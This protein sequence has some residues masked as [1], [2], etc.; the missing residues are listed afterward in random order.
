MAA[1]SSGDSSALAALY[2]RHSS[3]VYGLCVRILKERTEAEEVL[4]D[5]FLEIWNRA[6]RFDA[7]RGHPLTYLLSL[8]RSRALDRLRSRSR[9]DRVVLYTSDQDR[10]SSSGSRAIATSD[11]LRDTL[12]TELRAHLDLA[13]GGLHPAQ[14][15]AL[16][17]AYFDGM[18]HSEIAA[19]LGEPLGTVKTRI[20][21]GLIHL[22][23]SLRPHYEGGATP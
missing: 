15:R 1:I 10:S 17:L 14:R 2:D 3:T 12:V 18:S 4:G 9:R 21:Q 13:L 19:A 11:P 23:E 22:R 6:D 20:R 16:E 8:T 5:V 7:T